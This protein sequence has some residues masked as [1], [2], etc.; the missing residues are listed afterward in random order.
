MNRIVTLVIL[1]GAAFAQ[2]F[3]SSNAHSGQGGATA[4]YGPPRPGPVVTDAPYSA[5]QIQE[6]NGK[7]NV[8]GRFARDPQGRTRFERAYKFPPVWLTTIYDPVAGVAYL[9]DEDAKVAHRMAMPPYDPATVRP[10]IGR[11]NDE[12]LGEQV[13]NGLRLTGRRMNGPLTIE[14]WRS[15]ELQLD[16]TTR[17]S[18]GYSGRL[19]KL[20][21]GE[22]DPTLFRPPADYR[23]VDEAAP[24]PMTIRLK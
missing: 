17:S 6:Y 9:L 8:I 21:R 4:T 19:E 12:M 3:P 15:E 13:V 22:P 24:F 10:P 1:A 18:N 20:S 11:P 23:V 7:S 16:V 5:E 14:I 2:E